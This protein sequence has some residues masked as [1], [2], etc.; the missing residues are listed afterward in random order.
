[1]NSARLLRPALCLFALALTWVVSLDRS[2]AQNPAKDLPR[3]QL[4]GKIE[5]M[6][7]GFVQMNSESLKVT[8]PKMTAKEKEDAKT[9]SD[10]DLMKLKHAVAVDQ[11]VRVDA[12][13]MAS[14]DYIKPGQ[15][16]RLSGKIDG[17]GVVP[18]ELNAVEVFV[19]PQNFQ[20]TMDITVA[21]SGFVGDKKENVSPFKAEGIV[22]SNAR[23]RLVVMV[24]DNQRI[25]AT[26]SAEAKVMLS[27]KD[28]SLAAVGDKI[29]VTG[30]LVAPGQVQAESV[31]VTLSSLPGQAKKGPPT[32]NKKPEPVK[33]GAKKEETTEK[34]EEKK[35]EKAA[36]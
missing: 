3:I 32:A 11:R 20:P 30:R 13:A 4:S 7:A 28:L 36:G 25:Q 2:I 6:R 27:S 33:K 19:P 15:G 8:Y 5:A 26:V 22:M 31:S 21:F 16:I 24:K 14:V 18:N 35:T 17:N 10:E 9:T 23:G 34:A 1:M 12:S 29:S